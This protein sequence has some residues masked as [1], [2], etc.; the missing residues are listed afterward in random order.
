MRQ[1]TTA[2]VGGYAEKCEASDIAGR[3]VKW[4]S[5]V[6]KYFGSF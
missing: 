2:N 5:Y 3:N 4:Y 1:I 6:G